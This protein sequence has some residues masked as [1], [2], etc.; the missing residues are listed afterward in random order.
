MDSSN[1][2]ILTNVKVHTALSSSTSSTT[3]TSSSSSMSLSSAPSAPSLASKA[4]APSKSS[5]S[6]LSGAP[7]SSSASMASP[8]RLSSISKICIA[9]HNLGFHKFGPYHKNC[10]ENFGGIWIWLSEKQLPT[11][12]QLGTKF[13]A[14]SG[15]EDAVSSGILAGRP[16]G[17]VSISW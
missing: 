8:S 4:S 11:L 1:K 10:N 15:M 14:I 16:L 6:S 9:S 3:S 13:T 5:S 17:G 2:G 7:A 12:H